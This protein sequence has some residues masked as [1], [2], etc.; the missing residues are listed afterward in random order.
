[1]YPVLSHTP[2]DEG[3]AAV[4]VVALIVVLLYLVMFA[5]FALTYVLQSLGMYSIAKRRGIHNPWLAWIPVGNMWILGS[6]SDQYQYVVKGKVR[7]RRKALMG[8]M[9]AMLVV[10]IPVY[11]LYF[12]MIIFSAASPEEF[13]GEGLWVYGLVLILL[14]LVMMVITIIAVVIQYIA[15]YDFFVSCDPNNSVMYLVL[16]IFFNITLPFFMFACRKKDLGMPPRKPIEAV[17]P[18]WSPVQQIPAEP[19][20]QMPAE[21]LVYAEEAVAVEEPAPVEEISE[22]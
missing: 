12:M 19:V 11:V 5:F 16:S 9:I 14:A 17:Q 22:E 10:M 4:G 1:M 21:E 2:M 15:L 6:I 3:I 7:N 20:Q 13:A 8:L 18:A